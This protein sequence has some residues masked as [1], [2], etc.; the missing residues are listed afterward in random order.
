MELIKIPLQKD[1]SGNLL[2]FETP[3]HKY[4]PIRIGTPMGIQRWTVYEK[5]S[6]VTGF[7]KTFDHI[8]N[9]LMSVE[10]TLAS[11]RPF[12]E[13]R[14][15]CIL[16]IN[17]LWRGILEKSQERF[18]QSFWL[19][20]VFIVD[21]KDPEPLVWT[22]EKAEKMVSDWEQSGVDEQELLFFCLATVSGFKAH[23]ADLV[24]RADRVEAV[25][26]GGIGSRKVEKV[27]G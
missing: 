23:Y 12:P 10:K 2:P 27:G 14:L 26:S 21:D 5:L 22:S 13:I 15:E 8:V 3:K 11:D 25:L 18:T 4:T 20:T 7:G 17:S 16:T 19:A 9:S 1:E 24:E 6:V